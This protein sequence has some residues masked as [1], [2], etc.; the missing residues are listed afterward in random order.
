M[1]ELSVASK[2]L[3]ERVMKCVSLGLGQELGFLDKMHQ[4]MLS[5][6]ID[7]EVREALTIYC[8]LWVLS[9]MLSQ[10]WHGWGLP[11]GEVMI[12]SWWW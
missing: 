9:E 4:G 8:V 5:Q 2:Q 1:T 6:G 3:A 10:A 11:I 12:Q 7:G